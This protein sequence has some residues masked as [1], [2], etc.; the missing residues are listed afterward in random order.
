M[1][2][3]R[4]RAHL[5]WALGVVAPW[6]LAGGMLISFT[7]D[8]GQEVPS[9]ASHALLTSKAAVMPRDLMPSSRALTSSF[10][11]TFGRGL[12]HEARLVVGAPEQIDASPEQVEPRADLKRGAPAFPEIDRS[13]RGDPLVG[14]RP[15]FEGALRHKGSLAR[16]RAAALSFDPDASLASPGFSSS[17]N[18]ISGPKPAAHFE[19]VPE[20]EILPKATPKA[21]ALSSATPCDADGGPIV[22]LTANAEGHGA[23]GVSAAVANSGVTTV[24]RRDSDT[25]LAMIPAEKLDSEKR[26]LA[27]AIYFEARSEPEE[28]QAAVAQVIL[29]RMTSGLYPSSI[30]GVVFQNRQPSPRLPVLLRLRWSRLAR[31]R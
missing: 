6:C 27:Q 17:T 19:P 31:S 7:A 12:L 1:R 14:L 13:H 3:A 4:R 24:A 22:S 28:G 15:S 29:N 10:G 5:V 23:A 26:C 11:E 20:A 30:C 25:Y 8:A 18:G 21:A 16:L 9:G 2:Q